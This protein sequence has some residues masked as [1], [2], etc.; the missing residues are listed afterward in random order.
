MF[1]YM[2]PEYTQSLA[3]FGAPRLLPRCGGWVLERQIPGS[4]YRDAMGAYPLFAC[5][6]WSQLEADLEEIGKEWISLTLVSDPFGAYTMADLEQVFKDLLFPFKEH[7]VVDL[8]LPLNEIGG[9]RRRKHARRALRKVE[10]EVC[11]EPSQ[12]I[13][14]WLDLYSNLIEKHNIQGIRAFSRTAFTRQLNMPGTVV[15]RAVYEG[16]TIGA[17]LYFTQGDVAHCHLG[18]VNDTGYEVGAT[19]ALDWY[20]FEYFSDKVRWLNLGG[21]AGLSSNGTD[22]LSE[23]KRGWATDTRTA[24]LCG[25]IF[26]H[27]IYSELAKA[28]HISNYDYFPVYRKGEFA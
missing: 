1:G 20:S 23:Y 19:Y 25:H 17:Q 16:E 11:Q 24:Y 12:F 14:T 28:K 13:D 7:F 21:G 2:H 3:E 6:D 26:N 9:S 18:A 5:Q 27:A 22:G 4:P 15:L 8:H 10:I